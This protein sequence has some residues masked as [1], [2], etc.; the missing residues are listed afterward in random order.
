MKL[1]QE[2]KLNMAAIEAALNESD[3]PT[4]NFGLAIGRINDPKNNILVAF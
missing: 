1:T 2:S 3:H 4:V